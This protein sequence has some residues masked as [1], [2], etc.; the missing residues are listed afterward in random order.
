V[1]LTYQL[2]AGEIYLVDDTLT[3]FERQ[4]CGNAVSAISD[5]LN[6]SLSRDPWQASADVTAELQAE[7]K[8]I[9]DLID[10]EIS[11]KA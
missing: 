5:Q 6:A 2:D 3:E 8:E 7:L 1:V 11:P 4:V 9:R 10:R